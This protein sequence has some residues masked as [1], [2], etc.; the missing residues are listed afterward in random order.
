MFAKIF[1]L[2]ARVVALPFKPLTAV[3]VAL[4]LVARLLQS[5]TWEVLSSQITHALCV[6][7]L[8]TWLILYWSQRP[9]CDKSGELRA[10]AEQP[11]RPSCQ[12]QCIRI[13]G[14]HANGVSTRAITG[15]LYCDKS[16]ELRARAEQVLS[17]LRS[18]RN[19]D[20]FMV[21]GGTALGVLSVCFT[22]PLLDVFS[23]NWFGVACK[24]HR[25]YST[26]TAVNML[27]PIVANALIARQP[28]SG[29]QCD[30]RAAGS[31]MSGVCEFSGGSED[32]SDSKGSKKVVEFDKGELVDHFQEGMSEGS[33]I[34][35]AVQGLFEL[36]PAVFL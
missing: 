21:T 14:Y 35:D 32:Q 3:V 34:L 10:R 20:G 9:S 29:C 23:G 13:S 28:V 17:S 5:A 16:G 31:T 15:C 2:T 22:G 25:F 18:A 19:K 33:T 24:A 26:N 6:A 11:Q 36:V 30:K 1:N 12:C 4:R 27:K 8:L 7:A